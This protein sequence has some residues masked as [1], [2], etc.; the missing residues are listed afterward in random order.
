MRLTVFGLFQSRTR[1]PVLLSLVYGW[2]E[3]TALICTHMVRYFAPNILISHQK[4]HKLR[5]LSLSNQN[6]GY[7]MII[8]HGLL[9]HSFCL[10]LLYYYYFFLRVFGINN[11]IS[12]KSPEV[13]VNR[14]KWWGRRWH[15]HWT[16]G[17]IPFRLA[18]KYTSWWGSYISPPLII[19]IIIIFYFLF[20]I[21][22][23]IIITIKQYY[24]Y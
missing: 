12:R 11:D 13:L 16:H 4:I 21:I 22:I 18:E 3:K 10:C 6:Y 1:P 15:L 23:I 19:I 14:P 17:G 2:V 9:L 5:T 7:V 20:F 8:L 24:Y